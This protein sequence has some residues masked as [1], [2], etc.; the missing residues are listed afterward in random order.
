MSRETKQQFVEQMRQ[1]LDRAE[2]VL[3]LDY[4]GLTVSEADVLRRKLSAAKVAYKVVKNTLM[5]RALEG[6]PY[7]DVVK[8]LKGTPTGVVMGWEDPVTPAKLTFEFLKECEHIKIKGGV[9]DNRAIQAPEAEALSKMPS[10]E[11]LQ[12]MIVGQAMSPGRNVVS[13]IKSPAGR[14]LGAIEALVEK[15]EA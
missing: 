13:Q 9:V 3:F 6:T 12:S 8:C 7:S 5:A 1:D 10:R 15:Q 2:G 14:I 4:T 11:E